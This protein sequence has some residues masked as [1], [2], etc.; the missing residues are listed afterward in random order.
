[1]AQI[2]SA[3][4]FKSKYSILTPM[5]TDGENFNGGWC[6]MSPRFTSARKS[7]RVG[8]W[9]QVYNPRW[10]GKCLRGWNLVNLISTEEG[11][12]LI[13]LIEVRISCV[14]SSF[15]PRQ[16][17]QIDFIQSGQTCYVSGYASRFLYGCI[18]FSIHPFVV[19]CTIRLL[20]DP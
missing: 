7:N 18:C 11:S 10:R 8:T 6:R 9:E 16:E 5:D 1:M 14:K 2:A 3:W 15:F 13:F 17:Q 20:I 4:R 19:L 12:Y